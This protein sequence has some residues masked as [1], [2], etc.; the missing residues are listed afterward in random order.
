MFYITYV[1]FNPRVLPHI[2]MLM[3]VRF[4]RRVYSSDHIETFDFTDISNGSLG[5]C[6]TCTPVLIIKAS[7]PEKRREDFSR[8]R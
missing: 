7:L 5:F 4:L 6:T 3:A 8:P 1:K 2:D